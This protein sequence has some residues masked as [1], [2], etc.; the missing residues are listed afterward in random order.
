[1][2]NLNEKTLKKNTLV[3]EREL[4]KQSVLFNED[5][6]HTFYFIADQD[7]LCNLKHLKKTPFVLLFLSL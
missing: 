6:D 2:K 1:M 5:P 7:L 3:N 4:S